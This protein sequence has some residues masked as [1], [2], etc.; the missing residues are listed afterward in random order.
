MNK[1]ERRMRSIA[2]PLSTI[3][4][5]LVLS[6]LL[7]TSFCLTSSVV[8]GGNPVSTSEYGLHLY[9][10][11]ECTDEWD[12]SAFGEAFLEYEEISGGYRIVGETGSMSGVQDVFLKV[13]GDNDTADLHV[14]ASQS[15]GGSEWLSIFGS[16]SI[17]CT[18]ITGVRYEYD[19]TG[20]VVGESF[21]TDEIISTENTAPEESKLVGTV[22][23][24]SV[25]LVEIL[26]SCDSV[27][28]ES[29]PSD[30]DLD[31]EFLATDGT[32]LSSYSKNCDNSVDFSLRVKSY[33]GVGLLSDD[34]VFVEDD[35]YSIGGV[36]YNVALV[37]SQENGVTDVDNSFVPDGEKTSKA[38]LT[39]EK[40]VKFI[41]YLEVAKHNK[42]DFQ[43]TFSVS[44]QDDVTIDV[45]GSTF[46][47]VRSDESIGKMDPPSA[48]NGSESYWIVSDGTYELNISASVPNSNDK[49][50]LH[51]VI[52]FP[53]DQA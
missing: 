25:Y 28:V 48:G 42:T 29:V 45:S 43:L 5:V 53:A 11:F 17:V 35:T 44:G 46:I 33:K 41:L 9:S 4:A 8:S 37:A 30:F 51:F 32:A 47:G 39:I 20:A 2:L 38:K 36:D 1:T 40:G 34:H 50:D 49:H 22:D 18:E 16:V 23:V 7:P 21:V 6:S 27:T 14:I 10:D 24:G 12:T 19:E 31:L 13:V 3:L 15:S 52:V 26:L